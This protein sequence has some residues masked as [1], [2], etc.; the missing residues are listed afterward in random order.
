[1]NDTCHTYRDLLVA[2]SLN[3]LSAAERESLERHL[4]T[5]R[6]CQALAEALREDDRRLDEFVASAD[7]ALARIEQ[8]I[9]TEL[10]GPAEA[11]SDRT[12]RRGRE[13]ASRWRWLAA[14]AVLVAVVLG[15]NVVDPGGG[16]SVV[17][18]EVISRVEEAQDFICRRIEQKDGEPA[19]EILEYRSAKHGLR[20]D[21]RQDGRLQAT[22]YIVPDEHMLYALVHRDRTYM[23]Q[24]LTDE[25]ISELSRQSNASAIVASFRDQEYRELGR[26]TIDG[27]RSEGIEI[28]DPEGWSSVYE[29]GSWRLWVD[30]ETQW[31]V[32][33]ELEGYARGGAVHKTYTL[34]DFQ[35]NPELS[36]R[37][38]AVE[39]PEDYELIA[40]LGR[41]EATEEQ[42]LAGLEAYARLL[43]GQYPSRLSLATAIDEAEQ[44]LDARHDG[45]DEAAGHDLEALFTIRSACDFHE[46]LVSQDRDVRYYGDSVTATDF[47]RILMRWRLD[48]GSYR[49][50]FGDLRVATVT[51][52]RLAE[53]ENDQP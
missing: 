7:P 31:P 26:R 34:R 22:Q 17:W 48:D 5:C 11:R 8:R 20:Q 15:V 6:H 13:V 16:G 14:A 44:V 29:H 9:S 30:V 19:L 41:S 2:D 38:F 36:A 51:A 52:A 18:A 43:A 47:E 35:W 39:I 53:L 3:E 10:D 50:I 4:Q 33:I 32:R 28:V 1:M 12:S 24:R 46:E 45:Y 23:R 40:D 21:I 27:R 25:Q 42:T 37:D 49:V